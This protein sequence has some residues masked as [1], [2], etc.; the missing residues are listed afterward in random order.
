[1]TWYQTRFDTQSD[2]G[3]KAI[4]EDISRKAAKV[5]FENNA[6]KSAMLRGDA[7]FDK[8]WNELAYVVDV[9][10]QTVG[11]IPRLYEIIDYHSEHTFDPAD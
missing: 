6:V 3:D 1:M 11:G 10:V 2:T 7:R 8:P 4:I 9:R 5:I